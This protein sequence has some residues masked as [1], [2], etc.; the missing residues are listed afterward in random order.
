MLEKI[1]DENSV[2]WPHSKVV[3]KSPYLVPMALSV[4]GNQSS[5]A[6]ET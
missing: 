1:P 4:S 3:E 5:W 6:T 2:F